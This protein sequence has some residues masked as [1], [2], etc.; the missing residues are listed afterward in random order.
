[1]DY[2][3]GSGLNLPFRFERDGEPVV[4]TAG[5]VTYTVRSHTGTPFP[6]WE[7]VPLNVPTNESSVSI[8]IPAALNETALRIEKRFI[9][10]AY[11]LAGMSQQKTF[12][13]R[14][15]P[16]LTHTVNRDQVRAQLGGIS[17]ADLPDHEI[18]L[19]S[20]YFQIEDRLNADTL[21]A[22]LVAGTL[23]EITANNAI[24][25]Q[26]TLDVLPSV[27]L[28]INQKEMDGA[29][30]IERGDVTAMLDQLETEIRQKLYAAINNLSGR[31]QERFS[32]VTFST[33]PDPVTGA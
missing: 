12:T 29:I 23:R 31:V 10:V 9:T 13:Y 22:A 11:D 25:W 14:L 28:R 33:R 8:Q 30:S 19:V 5:S 32:L 27:K 21:T 24:L 18:D 26:A 6:G 15:I 4:P 7:G 1:M 16:F 17:A 3:T 20:A 2:L